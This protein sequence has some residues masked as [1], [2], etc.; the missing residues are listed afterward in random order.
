MPLTVAAAQ[1]SCRPGDVAGNVRTH[2]LL[3]RRAGTRVIV[4]PEL[5]LTGYDLESPAVDPDDPALA[6]LQEACTET[7]TLALV[8]AP[9][10]RADRRHIAM[11]AVEP[12]GVSVAYRK[13]WLGG[14]EAQSFA[15]GDGP[16]V[17]SVDGWRLGLGLCKDTG[18]AQHIAGTAALDVDVYL[19]GVVHRPDELA[20]QEARATVIARTCRA[21]T[22]IAG[23]V[24]A[25]G[26]Q[27]PDT[28]GVS[29]VWAPDGL[30][31]TRAGREPD[32]VVT[33]SLV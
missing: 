29:G 30:A 13:T 9:V 18:S 12:T 31:V 5:S 25:V 1:P 26:P 15:P 6:P 16:T 22:A 20:E 11:L 21:Y 2:A 23:A 24:G 14:D 17:L 7:G 33:A 27:Y 8:G 28:C 32:T 10:R 3:V 19:A 4:F